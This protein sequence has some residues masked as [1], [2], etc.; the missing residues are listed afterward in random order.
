MAWL[1]VMQFDSARIESN[2][3]VPLTNRLGSISRFKN[4]EGSYYHCVSWLD[5]QLCR[6]TPRES[7]RIVTYPWRIDSVRFHVLRTRKVCLM[8]WLPVMQFDSARI[9]SNRHVPLTNRLSLG[10]LDMDDFSVALL[11]VSVYKHDFNSFIW[12]VMHLYWLFLYFWWF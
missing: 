1:P 11:G 3:R 9:E 8:A 7:S 6:L 4:E 5:F 12:T 2:R 10:V